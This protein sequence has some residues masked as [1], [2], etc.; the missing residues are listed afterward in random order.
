MPISW[1]RSHKVFHTCANTWAHL[2]QHKGIPA[3]ELAYTCAKTWVHL[4]QDKTHQR[5]GM[6]DLRQHMETSHQHM[7]TSASGIAQNPL[8][9]R[10]E[11][12]N[13]NLLNF[14]NFFW[15]S[16]KYDYLCDIKMIS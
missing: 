8:L 15:I 4:H 13:K 12:A 6:A 5:Q 16:R 11:A 3:P 2:R 9:F 14:D 10:E 7:G 1:R